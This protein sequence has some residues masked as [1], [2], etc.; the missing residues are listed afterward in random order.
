MLSRPVLLSGAFLEAFRP[1]HPFLKGLLV[2]SRPFRPVL[3]SS[4]VQRGTG[5]FRQFRP[6]LLSSTLRE[7]LGAFPPVSTGFIVEYLA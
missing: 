2:L 7:G 5:V 6:F 4:T 3:L 1:V